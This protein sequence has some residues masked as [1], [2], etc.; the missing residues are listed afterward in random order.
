MPWTLKT[1]FE[2]DKRRRRRDLRVVPRDGL[3]L[4]AMKRFFGLTLWSFIFCLFMKATLS[5]PCLGKRSY[6]TPIAAELA[7]KK[8]LDAFYVLN[9]ALLLSAHLLV[10][11]RQDSWM[12]HVFSAGY[13]G[14]RVIENFSVIV[15][16]QGGPR[17]YTTSTPVR[18]VVLTLWIY[19]EHIIA[20]GTFF[21]L[22]AIWCPD[23]YRRGIE[24]CIQSG[25]FDALYF[26]FVTTTTLGYGDYS[27]TTFL[28]KFLVV[29]AVLGGIIIL[30]VTLQRT[31][32]TAGQVRLRNR[33][34]PRC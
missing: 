20:F 30:V 2:I 10:Y 17:A 21:L 26:S 12:W 31:V 4:A 16:L 9:G 25:F 33:K 23:S 1:T 28:G 24:P 29:L 22:S 14:Y 6:R 32:A 5:I 27:P 13:S 18:A 7:Y 8:V 11:F 19:I 34:R 3:V 15:R